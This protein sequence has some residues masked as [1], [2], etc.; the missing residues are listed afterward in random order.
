MISTKI[1][2]SKGGKLIFF[3]TVEYAE[4]MGNINIKEIFPVFF[5]LSCAFKTYNLSNEEFNNVNGM[6]TTLNV[7]L[8]LQALL[9]PSTI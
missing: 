6:L 5:I 2:T 7:K 8:V 4:K 3:L 1:Q 9:P